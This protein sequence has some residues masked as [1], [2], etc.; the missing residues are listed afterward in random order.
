MVDDQTSVKLNFDYCQANKIF[1]VVKN[2]KQQENG[3]SWWNEEELETECG[4]GSFSL[5]VQKEM[6]K[7]SF[8]G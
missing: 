4:T 1:C 6:L 7:R 2:G 3:D 8:L 5:I